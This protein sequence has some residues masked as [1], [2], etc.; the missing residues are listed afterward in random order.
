MQKCRPPLT[1]GG[2]RSYHV[3][4]LKRECSHCYGKRRCLLLNIVQAPREHEQ[5]IANDTYSFHSHLWR[6]QS[7]WA[8]PTC[9]TH[10]FLCVFSWQPFTMFQSPYE[11]TQLCVL[12][13]LNSLTVFIRVFVHHVESFL[14]E[15]SLLLKWSRIF[16]E[17]R[18]PSTFTYFFHFQYSIVIYFFSRFVLTAKLKIWNVLNFIM[19]IHNGYMALVTPWSNPHHHQMFS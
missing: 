6:I 5:L 1:R 15:F 12:C 16:K 11:S 3:L 17:T 14:A 4:L 18:R 9:A 8:I 19:F 7:S 10:N 2:L 13:S